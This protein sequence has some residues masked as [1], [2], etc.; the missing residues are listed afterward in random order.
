MPAC[1][2]RGRNCTRLEVARD[3]MLRPASLPR[4]YRGNWHNLQIPGGEESVCRPSGNHC[5]KVAGGHAQTRRW[6]N[7]TAG[8][9]ARGRLEAR[10]PAARA[11]CCGRLG[12]NNPDRP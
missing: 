5:S 11:V 4:D 8:S 12:S 6:V 1:Y 3:R 7:G 2:L 9:L 10:R